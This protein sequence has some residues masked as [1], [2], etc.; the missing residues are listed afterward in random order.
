MIE[1]DREILGLTETYMHLIRGDHHK[2]RDCHFK[3]SEV[4]SYG[5]PAYFRVEHDGYCQEMTPQE[6]SRKFATRE[7]AVALLGA[8][9]RRFI[10]NEDLLLRDEP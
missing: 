1:N 7:E 5:E 8:V 2:D 10:K 3:I 9:L 6:L 4:W